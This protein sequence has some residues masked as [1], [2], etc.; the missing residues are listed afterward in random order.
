MGGGIIGCSIAW[1]LAARDADVELFDF[2]QL[3]CEASS[4]GAGMLAPGGEVTAPNDFGAM[5]LESARI[6]PEYVRRITAI[7]A[8]SIDYRRCE[9]VEL[10]STNA[11]WEALQ[12][13]TVIQVEMGIDSRELDSSDLGRLLPG[14]A[15]PARFRARHYPGDALVDPK[16]ILHGLRIAL[17]KRKV[18]IFENTP[19]E[20]I[21]PDG[22]KCLING[23]ERVADVVVLAAGAWSSDLTNRV[24]RSYP[25]KGHLAGWDLA[26]GSLGPIV[27]HGHTYLMQRS[28]GFSIAGATT[29]RNAGFDRTVNRDTIGK[30]HCQA[31]SYLPE[32]FRDPPAHGWIGFRPRSV[33]ERPEIGWL[34]G[35]RLFQA[36]GHYRN[37]ILLAPV[38][39]RMAADRILA[40]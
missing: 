25:V 33:R 22:G 21:D 32:L 34:A 10:A 26:P 20:R 15:D 18:Q 24:P 40:V 5:A 16:D 35:T 14:L 2:G 38:T 27:R 36:Y 9:S 7:S 6:Y 3:G 8:T 29:E 4:A 30:L 23:T 12:A 28:T 37:G 19:V 11:E 31:V 39:A 13:K 1:E 17:E